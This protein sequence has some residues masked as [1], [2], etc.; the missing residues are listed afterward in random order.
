MSINLLPW[1]EQ[2]QKK[3]RAKYITLL[4]IAL[5]S[6]GSGIGVVRFYLLD[7]QKKYQLRNRDLTEKIQSADINNSLQSIRAQY[8]LSLQRVE[9]IDQVTQEK[10]DFWQ[11][12]TLLKNKLPA[13]IQLNNLI[14]QNSLLQLQGSSSSEEDINSLIQILE[15]SNLFATVNLEQIHQEEKTSANQFIIHALNKEL[16]RV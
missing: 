6:M 2:R 5:F 14:W 13:K 1:R 10:T 4:I 11:E 12:V 3:Y 9:I 7:L 8:Q 15:Q 16:K